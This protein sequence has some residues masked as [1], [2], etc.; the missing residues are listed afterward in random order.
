MVLIA[1][2]H[3]WPLAP[4][5]VITA[6]RRRRWPLLAPLIVAASHRR[7]RR[8]LAPLVVLR[9]SGP[10]VAWRLT[11][12]VV[13]APRCRRHCRPLA[14]LIVATSRC[15]RHRR[16][17]APLVVATSRRRASGPAPLIAVLLTSS[18]PGSPGPAF[19]PTRAH[20]PLTPLIGTTPAHGWF[21]WRPFIG[22]DPLTA[23]RGGLALRFPRRRVLVCLA[24]PCLGIAAS[25]TA[26]GAQRLAATF[27]M[28]AALLPG[29][30]LF[31][32]VAASARLAGHTARR[33]IPCPLLLFWS[34]LGF[35]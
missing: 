27:R 30:H 13:A 15:R 18:L 9:P 2:T 16:P 11:P 1:T 8:S 29:Q 25:R 24:P 6:H 12:L 21:G 17:L 19:I 14:P 34:Q 4:L 10:R 32:R 23:A 3:R 20:L 28:R 33:R 31:A 7:R 5:I 22:S 26:P 35:L